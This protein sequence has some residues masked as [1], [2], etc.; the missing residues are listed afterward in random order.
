MDG[1]GAL[2]RGESRQ[3]CSGCDSVKP[4]R[5]LYIGPEGIDPLGQCLLQ[6][7][8]SLENGMENVLTDAA[9]SGESKDWHSIDWKSVQLF[10]GKAQMSIAQA[11]TE[12]DFRRVARLT[13]SLLRSWQAKALAVRKVTEN[14][15]SE[16]VASIASIGI[17]QRRNG[18]R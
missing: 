10:V 18:M 1:I 6:W 8:T 16:R 12:R 5:L 14:R 4:L 3:T 2:P 9:S 11:E 7:V 15:G 17:R 13:R